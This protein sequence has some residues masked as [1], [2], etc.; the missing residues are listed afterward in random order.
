MVSADRKGSITIWAWVLSIVFHTILLALLALVGFSKPAKTSS[1]APAAKISVNQIKQLTRAPIISPKPKI[2]NAASSLRP[3]LPLQQLAHTKDADTKAS[4]SSNADNRSI[5]HLAS[6]F[7]DQHPPAAVPAN[8][9]D[10][11]KI[12]YVV[13]CSASMF[14]RFTAVKQHLKASIDSLQP[15]QFFYIIFFHQG[16]KLCELG[17]GKMIRATEK[18]KTEACSFVDTA[19]LGGTTDALYALKRAMKIKDSASKPPQ[20]IFFLTDGF[21]LH[22]NTTAD[23]PARLQQL[24]KQLAPNTIINTIAFQPATA[25]REIL[26]TITEQTGGQLID[27]E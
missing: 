13:D 27:I 21:D 15:D 10:L 14:G 17:N 20:V 2:K 4:F 7:S 25:D 8:S 9:A 6:I 18:A 23:F 22:N 26:K 19:R 16:R 24:R 11:R 1:P 3:Y 5:S 12:C